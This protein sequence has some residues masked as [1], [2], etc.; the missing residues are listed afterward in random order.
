MASPMNNIKQ[1][2]LYFNNSHTKEKK[3]DI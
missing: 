1:E 2:F 3:S